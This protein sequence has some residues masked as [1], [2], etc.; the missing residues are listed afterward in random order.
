M[1][2]MGVARN[3]FGTHPCQGETTMQ[4]W[5]MYGRVLG[6]ML[7]LV[8]LLAACEIFPAT[9]LPTAGDATGPSTTA[10]TRPAPIP[11]LAYY[12]IWFD[13]S[14]WKRAKTDLPMLG[15]YSMNDEQVMQQHVRWAKQAGIDGFIVSW[16]R[17]ETLNRRLQK[18]VKIANQEQFKLLLIYQGLDFYRNPLPADRIA[19]D[20]DYALQTY[21]H[22]PAFNMFGRPVIIWSGTWK[23]SYD[24]IAGVTASRRDRA[25]ILASERNTEAYQRIADIVDGNAY[26][27]SSVDPTTFPG[28]QQKLDQM[29]QAVHANRGL[30]IAPA[31]PGFDA[32][33]I[34]GTRIVD[35]KNGAT[36][37]QQMDAALQSAPDAVG[38]ISWNE[39]SEHSYVEPS[40]Q[41]GRRYLDVLA[42]LRQISG[43]SDFDS[44]EPGETQRRV[45]NI[46]SL[47]GLALVTLTSLGVLINRRHG[48]RC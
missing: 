47:A 1:H 5:T 7:G 22:D 43:L 4:R 25:L 29:S 48:R 39:F 19:T 36:L 21:A 46:V 44:S 3:V 9:M 24:Q 10:L 33:L 37:R 32:R 16:K 20:L 35:R 18:L 45:T 38:I 30:W 2:C 26:Y 17:T 15:A 13:P 12:Y 34:G 6:W 40:Q 23:F 27:W 14:S 8:G 41:Y 31:A 11:V 28:Y 42:E